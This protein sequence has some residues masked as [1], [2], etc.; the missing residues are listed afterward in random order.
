M[1]GYPIRFSVAVHNRS[2]GPSAIAAAIRGAMGRV[3]GGPACSRSGP[4]GA[5]TTDASASGSVAAQQGQHTPVDRMGGSDQERGSHVQPRGRSGPVA[6]QF[7]RRGARMR[8]RRTGRQPGSAQP[9]AQF[10]GEQHSGQFGVGVRELGVGEP[11]P[12]SGRGVA[13]GAEPRCG[14]E[15]F[16]GIAEIAPFV[17]QRGD[18]GDPCVGVRVSSGSSPAVR[19]KAPTWLM[20]MCCSMPSAV[21][22]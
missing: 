21:R 5:W 10:H 11:V 18:R 2:P 13:V 12:E 9:A 3:S 8:V 4:P 16:G 1:T 7:G 15:P 19:A 6:E 14:V 20:P 17:G 22:A